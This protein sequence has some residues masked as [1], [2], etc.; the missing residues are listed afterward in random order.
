MS[1]QKLTIAVLGACSAGVHC[2]SSLMKRYCEGQFADSYFP[3]IEC[4]YFKNITTNDFTYECR[5]I[6]TAGQD[7]ASILKDG[8]I[9]GTHVYVLVYSVTSRRSFDL[10]RILYDDI[11]GL[12]GLPIPCVVVGCKIDL[13]KHR[14]VNPLEGKQLAQEK[15]SAW[16]ETTSKTDTNI[17]KVFCP[18]G[19]LQP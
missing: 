11:S 8:Y 12:Y 10:V 19:C 13:E 3:T 15:N 7:E 16:V 18:S 4:S 17:G 2:K 1:S 6:D 9:Y 5:I 14:T